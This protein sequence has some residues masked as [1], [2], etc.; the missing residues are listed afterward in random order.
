MKQAFSAVKKIVETATQDAQTLKER[1]KELSETEISEHFHFKW[2]GW[3]KKFQTK[4]EDT[5]S[6][7]NVFVAFRTELYKCFPSHIDFLNEELLDNPLEM[8]EEYQ[9]IHFMAIATKD[10][11]VF[12]EEKNTFDKK[13]CLS[14]VSSRL[15]DIVND[16]RTY[17]Q[18]RFGEE[19]HSGQASHIVKLVRHFSQ[20]MDEQK[21]NTGFTLGHKFLIAFAVKVSKC[22][23]NDIMKNVRHFQK[24]NDPLAEIRK[25]KNDFLKLFMNTYQNIAKEHSAA[26]WLASDIATWL[27]LVVSTKIG[28]LI[29]NAV[30]ADE[31]SGFDS[32]HSFMNRILTEIGENRNFQNYR[33]YNDAQ[34][35]FFRKEIQRYVESA[36]NAI[37]SLEQHKSKLE[38]LIEKEL[39]SYLS[40]IKAGFEQLSKATTFIGLNDYFAK[41]KRQLDAQSSDQTSEI[42]ML[43]D[44]GNISFASTLEISNFKNFTQLILSK[45]STIS[46][47]TMSMFKCS[48]EGKQTSIYS[49][50]LFVSGT[51]PVDILAEQVLGCMARCHFC[52]APCKYT[53]KSHA[54]EHSALQHRPNGVIGF[55]SKKT[56][57][58]ATHNCQSA[59][60]SN[61]S[62]KNKDTGDAFVPFKQYRDY[63]PDW[64]IAPDRNMDTELFWKW[65]MVA[66]HD[67][68]V[69]AF[70]ANPA[71]IPKEWE[72]ISWEEARKNL[73][74]SC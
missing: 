19:F 39:E 6:K 9:F 24:E 12:N 72:N 50:L 33:Y 71:D 46:S 30:L 20:E 66:F 31:S 36:M 26:E 41:L 7:Q 34:E 2:P 59:V 48:A 69:S 37:A 60:G 21:E 13:E 43:C 67:D 57:K 73:C 62:F 18:A 10:D 70:D 42:G 45:W 8:Y 35:S 68:L 49:N 27:H 51:D 53:F 16:V 56:N 64:D 3:L 28:P 63:Y 40:P 5:N 55:K 54:G 14:T 47:R 22:A 58:L 15:T 25:R 23:F 44:A 74:G 52:K 29:V 1:F 17:I 38:V 4:S 61:M 11:L 65:F 32:K